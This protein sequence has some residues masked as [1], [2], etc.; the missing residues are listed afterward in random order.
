MVSNPKTSWQDIK[1]LSVI[2]I[3]AVCGMLGVDI[4]LA[5]MPFIMK[6]LHTDK[7]HMQQSVS[8]FLLG[9][10][11][12]LLFYGPLS[13]KYGR[14]PIVVFGL[15]LAAM[16]SF[17][18]VF[19]TSIQMFL[20]LRL[21]QG[22]GSAVC[23]GLGKIILA[24]VMQGDKFATTGSYLSMVVSFSP[25]FAPAVGGYLQHWFDWKA[26]FIALGLLLT[27]AMILYAILCPETNKYKNPKAF[28]P[29]IIYH[30]Y[31][32]LLTHPVF[33]GCMVI[34]GLVMAANMTYATISSFIF[35]IQFKVSP[36]V[37]GWLTAIAGAGGFIGKM[38]NPVSI[39]K[40]SSQK[41]MFIGLCILTLAGVWLMFFISIR[42]I[43]LTLIMF[44]VFATNFSQAFITPNSAAIALSP[45][46]DKRG[47]A[48]A[49]YSSTQML[50]AFVVT[51]LAGSLAHDGVIVLAVSF[52]GLGVMGMFI[53]TRIF[54]RQTIK[55]IHLS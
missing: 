10:G 5:S 11:A 7:V 50:T 33:V 29:H 44:A 2:A 22:I 25:L 30:N 13:D 43:N 49:L 39:K 45:F 52:I 32:S 15:S 12:S 41:T 34:T 24:D 28:T 46:H 21:L 9:M 48:G 31:K 54:P 20:V 16:A 23:L 3:V 14:K 37:Y 18:T 55:T 26:N 47:A 38:I 42:S 1:L 35:Q 17:T 53:Y 8:I 36:I 6:F 4:H 51:A 27:F 19:V 40:I